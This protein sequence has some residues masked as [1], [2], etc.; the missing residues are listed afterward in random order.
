VRIPR[1]RL[2]PRTLL[3]QDCI[4]LFVRAVPP[5]APVPPDPFAK[6]NQSLEEMYL[7]FRTAPFKNC[8][9]VCA[10]TK[11]AVVINSDVVL[12][13]AVGD[14]I[15]TTYYNAMTA[16]DPS[17]GWDLMT[18]GGDIMQG[19]GLMTPL[20]LSG[21]GFVEVNGEWF[22]GNGNTVPAPGP[23]TYGIPAGPTD[24]PPYTIF[25]PTGACLLFLQ[26]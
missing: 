13:Y 23:T 9:V 12:A 19:N 15:G 17:Y 21:E 8:G 1:Q 2:L 22:D 7:E 3:T 11:V 24:F 4:R 26:C 14:A 18:Q 25:D 5:P 6:Y 20:G 10:L 16:I